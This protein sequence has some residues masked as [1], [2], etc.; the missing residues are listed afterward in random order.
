MIGHIGLALRDI[1]VKYHVESIRA[2]VNL[3]EIKIQS[4]VSTFCGDDD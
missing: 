1:G 4:E 3:E 2:A